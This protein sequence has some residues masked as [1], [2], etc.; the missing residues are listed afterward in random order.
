MHL[1]GVAAGSRTRVAHTMGESNS[2]YTTTTYDLSYSFESL[3]KNNYVFDK[4]LYFQVNEQLD[5]SKF[6]Y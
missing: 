3:N 2:I 4:L 1:S 6:P 5:P